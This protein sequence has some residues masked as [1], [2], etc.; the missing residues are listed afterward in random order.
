MSAQLLNDQD[1]GQNRGDG[2][3]K[4]ST[5]SRNLSGVLNKSVSVALPSTLDLFRNPELRKRA[6]CTG[7]CM[8]CAYFNFYGS[9]FGIQSLK[10]NIYFNSLI[11]ALADFVSN[12]FVSPILN[13]VKRKNTFYIMFGMSLTA[14]VTYMFITIPQ[15]CIDDENEY[16]W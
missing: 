7:M 10:G 16:C 12:F 15:T 11:G 2:A 13:N 14:T 5:K 1:P 4:D 9:L 6:I 8:F 3:E